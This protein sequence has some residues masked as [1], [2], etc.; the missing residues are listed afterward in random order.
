MDISKIDYFIKAAELE[1]FTK[2]ADACNIAQTTM[3]KYISTLETEVGCALFIREKKQVLL[4][5]QGKKFY[6]GIKSIRQ[7]YYQLLE[8]LVPTSKR[9]L[10][11]GIAIQDYLEIPVL[12]AFEKA[13]PEILI[14][15][16]FR[17]DYELLAGLENRN[18]DACVIPDALLLPENYEHE[19]MLQIHQSI[20]CSKSA[21]NRYATL[22]EI[23]SNLPLITKSNNAAY[24]NRCQENFYR[25]FGVSCPDII[26][27]TT[28]AEQLLH[29]GMSKGFAILPY[30][31]NATFDGLTALPLGDDF[32]ET[33][34]LIYSKT[35]RSKALEKLLTFIH[36]KRC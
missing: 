24:H 4:T 30:S 19:P 18:I 9:S 8:E 11:L 36:E 33:A 5:E 20:V 26:V 7:S 3:S 27:C 28:L 13:F 14:C 1:N 32:R 21:I 15:F 34:Q 16:S 22:R 17:P 25:L 6:D 31:G 29:V 35:G 10:C 2:A 12:Q 23:I